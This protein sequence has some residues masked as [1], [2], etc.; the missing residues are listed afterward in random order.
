MQAGFLERRVA[1]LYRN[2]GRYGVEETAEDYISVL[3]DPN[4]NFISDF[5]NAGKVD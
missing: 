1:L 2:L 5:A 4:A 3:D